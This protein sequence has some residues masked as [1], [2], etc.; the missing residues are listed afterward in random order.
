MT[1]LQQRQLAFLEETAKFYNLSTRCVDADG[2][3]KY[4]VEGK[5]GCALGR[6]IPDKDLCRKL[7]NWNGNTSVGV[8]C[9]DAFELMPDN[10][11]ELGQD[12]LEQVQSMH[13]VITNWVSD[14]LS[15]EGTQVFN[16]IKLDY[17]LS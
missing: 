1:P 10:L 9:D 17:R 5:A 16:R 14:G 6:H 3:C 4:Y 8:S 12:F 15:P 2:K 13:D 11:R 7:D